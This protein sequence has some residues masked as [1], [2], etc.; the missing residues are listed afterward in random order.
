MPSQASDQPPVFPRPVSICI[1]MPL[2][3]RSPAQISS[4]FLKRNSLHQ[5]AIFL[6][7][8]EPEACGE[9][10]SAQPSRIAA[11]NVGSN[12]L[13]AGMPAGKTA[14]NGRFFAS[15]RRK[16][17]RSCAEVNVE[18]KTAAA[19]AA[20]FDTAAPSPSKPTTLAVP[21]APFIRRQLSR[22]VARLLPQRQPA[23]R[24]HPALER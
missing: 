18:I 2:G 19:N 17:S 4:A 22:S 15:A 20:P 7:S 3:E 12:V 13:S 9:T 21:S 11:A 23:S 5:V 6:L 8:R 1:N 10:A 24:C 14:T 16:A